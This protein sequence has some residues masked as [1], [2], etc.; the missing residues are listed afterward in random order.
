MDQIMAVKSVI[1]WG[2]D[3]KKSNH[4]FVAASF[5]MYAYGKVLW[6]PSVSHGAVKLGLASKLGH[7]LGA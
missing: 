2:C 5:T 6:S 3:A 4:S 1:S 7:V